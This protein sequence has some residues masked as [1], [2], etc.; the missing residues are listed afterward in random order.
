M[1]QVRTKS[2]GKQRPRLNMTSDSADNSLKSNQIK[3]YLKEAAAEQ[4][5]SLTDTEDNYLPEE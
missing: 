3:R 2:S 4:F 5:K 1:V